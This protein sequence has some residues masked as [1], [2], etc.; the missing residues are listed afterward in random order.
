MMTVHNQYL[1]SAKGDGDTIIMNLPQLT[2][3][4]SKEDATN[5]V[6]WL[7]L[8]AGIGSDELINALQAIKS[9]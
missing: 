2:R 6:C 5:L 9:A 7:I 3:G 8:V 1:V 4:M